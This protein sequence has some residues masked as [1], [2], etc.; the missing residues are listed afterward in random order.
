M[1]VLA[2]QIGESVE[3]QNFGA[4]CNFNQ[5]HWLITKASWKVM[6]RRDETRDWK[7]MMKVAR[8]QI[9]GK[10]A[11]FEFGAKE[12]TIMQMS[13]LWRQQKMFRVEHPGVQWTT[14]PPVILLYTTLAT[15]L[16]FSLSISISFS[17]FLF[18]SFSLFLEKQL[19]DGSQ[20][21]R[22]IIYANEGNAN[23]T[24]QECRKFCNTAA[25]D[26]RT[27][28]TT[29]PTATAT[30]SINWLWITPCKWTSII[31]AINSN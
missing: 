24:H 9:N 19:N 4:I 26:A 16:N 28:R 20:S 3:R 29:D 14:L 21:N 6:K 25:P 1:F 10:L 2:D 30:T 12:P 13:S 8:R 22:A 17:L 11:S 7:R 15:F 31:N 23:E 27:R 18:L 5:I